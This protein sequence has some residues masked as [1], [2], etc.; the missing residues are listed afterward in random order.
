MATFSGR[1]SLGAAGVM[2]CA[3]P[4]ADGVMAVRGSTTLTAAASAGG[5]A[6]AVIGSSSVGSEQPTLKTAKVR[7]RNEMFFIT[8][9]F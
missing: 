3:I 9:S 7:T 4:G 5:G 8:R 1:G 6:G 2:V